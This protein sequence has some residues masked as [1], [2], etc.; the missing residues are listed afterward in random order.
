MVR[1]QIGG[2]GHPGWPAAASGAVGLGQGQ[3]PQPPY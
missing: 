3:E 1:R 2:V